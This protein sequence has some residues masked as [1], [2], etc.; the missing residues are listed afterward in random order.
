MQIDVW[1]RSYENASKLVD[2]CKNLHASI[3]AVSDIKEAVSDSDVICTL[4]AA[5]EP[6]LFSE[7][8]KPGC[9]INAVGACTI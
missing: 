4:T 3:R 8:I 2:K 5:K 7:W 6:I 1:S 9:H